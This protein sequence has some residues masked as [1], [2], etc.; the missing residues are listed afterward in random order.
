MAVPLIEIDEIVLVSNNQETR[1]PV[2][3]VTKPECSSL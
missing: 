3:H 2:Y 1:L